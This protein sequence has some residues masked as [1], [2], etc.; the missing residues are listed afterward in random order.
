MAARADVWKL[1]GKTAFVVQ[2]LG[3]IDEGTTRRES[4]DAT[5]D[6]QQL[7]N[8]GP[9]GFGVLKVVNHLFLYSIPLSL[10]HSPLTTR[11]GECTIEQGE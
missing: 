9:L 4:S 7:L 3:V 6:S 10:P 11:I 5:S 8:I 2:K 1:F